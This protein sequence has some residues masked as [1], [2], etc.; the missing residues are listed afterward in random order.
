MSRKAYLNFWIL[1]MRHERTLVLFK[2]FTE[3]VCQQSTKEL[4]L[5]D[6][7]E[8]LDRR[9]LAINADIWNSMADV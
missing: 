5:F 8:E 9:Q 1:E 7:N 2:P 4:V 3:V 6:V